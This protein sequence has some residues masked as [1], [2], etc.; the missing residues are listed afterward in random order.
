MAFRVS[1]SRVYGDGQTVSVRLAPARHVFRC[2]SAMSNQGRW[3][4]DLSA[5]A[6]GCRSRPAAAVFK[7][8][9]GGHSDRSGRSGRGGFLWWD[10]AALCTSYCTNAHIPPIQQP[11]TANAPPEVPSKST[12]DSP[13][14][15]VGS[16][17]FSNPRVLS[18]GT[19]IL[20]C[21][22]RSAPSAV[23]GGFPSPTALVLRQVPGPPTQAAILP[24]V[25]L[26]VVRCCQ[27]WLECLGSSFR[28]CP[29]GREGADPS[30]SAHPPALRSLGCWSSAHSH[31][32]A[33]A[34]TRPPSAHGYLGKFDQHLD[35]EVGHGSPRRRPQ[36]TKKVLLSNQLDSELHARASSKLYQL[37]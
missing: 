35:F 4:E 2:D 5:K 15:S 21:E 11:E 28:A 9:C 33:L 30:H 36:N 16:A 25:L 29:T 19:E 37:P 27:V 22:Y 31:W 3:G 32:T 26:G 14:V 20:L 23:V 1:R 24:V 7:L 34:K 18:R 6:A 12:V 10:T 17:G 8:S 13:Q